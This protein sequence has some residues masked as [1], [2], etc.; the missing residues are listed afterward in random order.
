MNITDE[1]TL[2]C[3]RMYKI[4]CFL[5][6]LVTVLPDDII[7]LKMVKLANFRKILLLNTNTN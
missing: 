3:N 4:I 1:T 2:R 7:C 6:C 5:H